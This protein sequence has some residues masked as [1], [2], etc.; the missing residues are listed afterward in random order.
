MSYLGFLEDTSNAIEASDLDGDGLTDIVIGIHR[1]QFPDM[2][3]KRLFILLNH[4][5]GRSYSIYEMPHKAIFNVES[6]VIGDF[7][8][9]GKANDIGACSYKSI[10]S[11]FSTIQYDNH[12]YAGYK[13]VDNRIFGK[14][15][16]IIRGRF[17][18]DKFDDLALVSP[19]TDTLHVLLAYGD[20]NR[21]FTQ[22]IYHSPH[23]PVSVAAINFNNDP[24]DDLAVLSCNQTIRMYLGTKNGIF[25]ENDIS[26]YVG[27]NSTNEC[28]RSLRSA[29]LNQDG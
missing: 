8:N 14:P 10:V 13:K 3:S 24:I 23:N 19:Q 12:P 18:D 15:Q 9:D 7:N 20:G 27:E 1:P 28:Y 26:F 6:I 29:D 11:T 21:T 22:Q 17:N 2:N 5:D 25:H 16:S 4:G